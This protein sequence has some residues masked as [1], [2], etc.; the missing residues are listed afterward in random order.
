MP[1]GQDVR[2]IRRHGRI[3]PIKINREKA[4]RKRGLSLAVAGA[5][6]AAGGGAVSAGL[7]VSADR[8]AKRAGNMLSNVNKVMGKGFVMGS[9]KQF[10]GLSKYSVGRAL[11]VGV[12][13]HKVVRT[14]LF[15]SKNVF[16]ASVGL[17]TGLVAAGA[18]RAVSQKD[19]PASEGIIGAAAG[20]GSFA[21]ANR[22]FRKIALK[23]IKL[24]L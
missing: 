5:G 3:I 18:L 10:S 6:V 9:A 1:S 22:V 17:G 7:A 15:L 8:I 20:V 16:R 12:K 14:R 23:R 2:F 24:P 11:K 21:L 4:S 19:R 13:A